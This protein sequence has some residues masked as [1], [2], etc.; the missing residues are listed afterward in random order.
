MVQFQCLA[1]VFMLTIQRICFGCTCT[2]FVP[3][4][5]P[6]ETDRQTSNNRF[7]YYHVQIDAGNTL[8]DT[9][10]LSLASDERYQDC[11]ASPLVKNREVVDTQYLVVCEV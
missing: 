2:V 5:L 3:L 8:H 11:G 9:D 4:I 1:E 6:V 7:Y 10:N